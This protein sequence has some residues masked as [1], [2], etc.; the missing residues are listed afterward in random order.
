MYVTFFLV[1]LLIGN[2]KGFKKALYF[3]LWRIFVI[4]K[5]YNI[6]F[7][8]RKIKWHGVTVPT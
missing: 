4:N 1:G 2:G 6:G 8:R 3:L 5:L 7:I